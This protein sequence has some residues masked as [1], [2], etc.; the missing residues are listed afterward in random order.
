MATLYAGDTGLYPQ[1]IGTCGPE[2]PHTDYNC[3]V[4]PDGTPRKMVNGGIPQLLNMTAHL[5]K[6]AAD[7]V[8]ILPDPAWSGVANLG[9]ELSWWCAS[10]RIFLTQLVWNTV[11]RLGSLESRLGNKQLR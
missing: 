8:R 5:D 1:I 9:A 3:S 11:H 6:W 10:T 7:I 4:G 2:G